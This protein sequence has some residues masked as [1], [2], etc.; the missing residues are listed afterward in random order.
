LCAEAEAHKAADG[1]RR[2]LAD[3][4]NRAD[5]LVYSTESSLADYA[6]HLTA[7]ERQAFEAALVRTRSA[8]AG[9]DQAALAG[10]VEELTQLSYKMTEKLYATLGGGAQGS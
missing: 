10:A 2:E 4:R 1:Q 9:G 6:E 7:E 5:G 3:L 8:L